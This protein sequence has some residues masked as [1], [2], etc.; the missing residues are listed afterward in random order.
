MRKAL[1]K[2][3][4]WEGCLRF[5]RGVHGNEPDKTQPCCSIPPEFCVPP[6]GQVLPGN[7]GMPGSEVGQSPGKLQAGSSWALAVTVTLGRTRA[8]GSALVDP[9]VT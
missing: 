3:G 8:P 9:G 4:S 2:S 5:L 6:A 7:V 1:K